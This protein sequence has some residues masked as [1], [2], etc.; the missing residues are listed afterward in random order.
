MSV[1]RST[2]PLF[3]MVL[4]IIPS[5][6]PLVSAEEV[7]SQSVDGFTVIGDPTLNDLSTAHPYMI[8]DTSE[9]VYSATRHMIQE[10]D[11]SG[12]SLPA[13]TAKTSARSC[14]PWASGDTTT[15]N[16]GGGDKGFTVKKTTQSVAFLVE[17]GRNLQ[18]SVLNDWATT[19]DQTIY[20]IMMSL[21]FLMLLAFSV[22]FLDET[23]SYNKLFYWHTLR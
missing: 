23:F 16:V 20:P 13:L 18:S 3:L 11:D 21:G 7:S 2:T 22:M 5:L 6:L 10:F 12:L 9:P 1:N 4:M 15:L 19:W 14:T 8:S 17:D